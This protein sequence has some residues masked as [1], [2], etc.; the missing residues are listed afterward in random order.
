MKD[1]KLFDLGATALI[2]VLVIGTVYAANKY[3]PA[4]N[5]GYNKAIGGASEFNRKYVDP[6]RT[7]QDGI[8][9]PQWQ[10][11]H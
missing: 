7:P 4:F 11:E 5:S 9:H 6:Y 10:D 2:I 8:D 1:F 3:S